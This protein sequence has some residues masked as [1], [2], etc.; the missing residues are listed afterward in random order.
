MISKDKNWRGLRGW[1]PF[2][3][4]FRCSNMFSISPQQYSQSNRLNFPCRCSLWFVKLSSAMARCIARKNNT[5]TITTK[6]KASRGLFITKLSSDVSLP[7]RYCRPWMSVYPADCNFARTRCYPTDALSKIFRRF[8]SGGTFANAVKR[9]KNTVRGQL[10]SLAGWI[11]VI[12][13]QT[14]D[15]RSSAERRTEVN[16]LHLHHDPR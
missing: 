9:H 12:V 3:T 10:D 15:P 5:S 4:R 7:L 6:V 13:L 14:L 2:Q 8:C 11:L 1:I 16:I